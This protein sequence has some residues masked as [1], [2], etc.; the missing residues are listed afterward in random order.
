MKKIKE[1]VEQ[2]DEELCGAKEY[3]E[4]ALWYKAK[5]DTIRYNKYKEMAMQELNHADIIH[6]FAV[7]DIAKLTETFPEPPTE[8]M[9]KWNESHRKYI[10]KVAWIKQ[11]IAM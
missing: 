10:E 6:S 1:Y 7:E 5:S 8:M 4:K 2:I 9:E 11:M 3:I